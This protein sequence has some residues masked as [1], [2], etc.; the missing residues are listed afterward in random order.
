MLDQS[1]SYENF[2]ILLDVENRKGRYLEDKAFF[3]SD[4]FKKSRDV[5]NLIIDKNQE[6]R[7]ES[8]RV[9]SIKIIKDRD[10][11]KLD[12]LK[13]EKQ[14]LKKIREEVLQEILIDIARKTDIEDYELKIKK[15]QIKWG[16]QLY[17]IERNPENYFVTKQLQ[18]NI[19]KTFKVKQAS[20][21]TII[22][23]LRLLLDDG[24]P[25][26]II[27]TDIKKFYE[28]IPH[29][30]LL[31]IIEENSLLSYPSKKIIRRVLNLYWN[32]LIADGTKTATDERQGIPRGIGFS[33]YLAE[34]YLRGFDKKIKSLSNVTYYSRYVDDIIIVITPS[35]RKEIKSKTSYINNIKN[36]LLSSSKLGLN[37]N[38]TG[39]LNL[40]KENRERKISQSYDLTYLGYK[41]K[42]NYSKK[43]ETKGKK[44]LT[45][46]TK[47][48]LQVF[49]SDEK[50]QRYKNKINTSFSD[51]NTNILKYASV[52]NTTERMLYKRLKFLTKNHRL[53]RRKSNVFIGVYFS[54]EFLTE[55]YADLTQ[56]DNY[57]KQKTLTLPTPTNSKLRAKINALSFKKGFR[58]KSIVRFD[59]DSF[60]NGKMIKIWKGL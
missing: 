8:F 18:R 25:K 38:K 30:E 40:T 59:I 14:E 9:F 11:T 7:D 31:A 27:R 15:G 51:Y 42:L 33:A 2:R 6:I 45:S 22:D 3:D 43:T 5:S 37:S 36:I 56:L 10:Y 54:N 29:K 19:Y 17:E 58:T 55:P 23:Q 24:F 12:K 20:R 4:F 53:F 1:F 34:L 28:S 44:I 46:I 39:V 41:F 50:L 48:K 47:D 52:K 35:H 26:I 21:K 16:S 60:K 32:I 49:M 57:L 13:E